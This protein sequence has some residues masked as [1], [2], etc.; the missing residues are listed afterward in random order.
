M[1]SPAPASRAS[2]PARIQDVIPQVL[3][4]LD[5]SSRH[6]VDAAAW[7]AVAGPALAA[8]SAP[9]EFHDGRLTVHV[10]HPGH[11][12][13]LHLKQREV[14]RAMQQRLGPGVVQEVRFRAGART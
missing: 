4:T 2:G 5:R 1:L 13:L 11:L 3:Q 14:L 7:R 9:A 10:D 8:H 12:F 6:T